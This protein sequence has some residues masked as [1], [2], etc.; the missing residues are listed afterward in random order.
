MGVGKTAVC[1]E[2][3]A[4]LPQNVFLDGDWCWSARTFVVSDETK[5]MVIDNITHL[6]SNFLACTAYDN[7]IF[8]WVMHEQGI[9]DALLSRLALEGVKV[10]SISLLCSS[11]ELLSRLEGDVSAGRR[12]ADVIERSLEYLP[13]YEK[14]DTVKINTDGKA[15]ARIARGIAEMVN[16]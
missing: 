11:S 7:V 15:P 16:L 8:C 2:L 13:L 4:L 9:I 12:Q 6:M 10:Y 5:A 3:L 1:R 14:L